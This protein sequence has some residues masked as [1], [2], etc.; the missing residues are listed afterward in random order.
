MNAAAPQPADP[1]YL[2]TLGLQ[3]APFLDRIDDRFF[4]ADPALVQRLDLLQHLTQ[5]GD[6]LLGVIGPPGSG[7]STLLQQFI[8]RGGTA[9]RCCR[10]NGAQTGSVDELLARL[11]AGFAVDV[12]ADQERTKAALL[13]QFQS[14]RHATQL[15]VILIDDALQLPDPILKALL[16]LGGSAKDTLKLVRIAL[17]AEPGLEQKLIQAGLHSPQQPLLHSLDMPV[18]DIQQSAAYLMYRLAVAGYSGD[19]PFSL[20]E[21]RALHKAA[22]GLPGKLNVLAHETLMERAGR[23]A[24]RNKTDAGPTGA[25]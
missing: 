5:F 24:A 15:P 17:F 4:Y 1:D 20:T 25:T 16:A 10:I 7:K 18:F 9:W 19:S 6:M 2:V 12:A 11:G 3:R 22:E 14:L 23:I 21:I 13:R 8:T